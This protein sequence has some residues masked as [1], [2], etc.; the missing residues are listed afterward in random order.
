[1]TSKLKI[2]AI[3]NQNNNHFSLIRY[4]LGAGYDADLLLTNAEQDHFHPSCDS[5]DL[6]YYSFT[7]QLCWGSVRS[8]LNTPK[9]QIVDDL[10]TYDILIGTGLAPAYVSR[11]GM[12][13]DVFDEAGVDGR[14]EAPRTWIQS[15]RKRLT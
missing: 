4:L 12:R 5:Y 3:G 1:M 14:S 10:G 6:S 7:K 8:F 2:A 13:L 11:A 9:N 15:I